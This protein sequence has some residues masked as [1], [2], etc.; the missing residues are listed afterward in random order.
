MPEQVVTESDPPSARAGGMFIM[1]ICIDGEPGMA[2]PTHAKGPIRGALVELEK[3]K[4][5]VVPN[6][7]VTEATALHGSGG[8]GEVEGE[9]NGALVNKGSP[10]ADSAMH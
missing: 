10:P 1:T 4:L 9:G 6:C 2:Y 3:E 5:A 7:V 8:I